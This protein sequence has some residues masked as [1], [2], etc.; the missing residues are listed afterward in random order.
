MI[1]APALQFHQ[2]SAGSNYFMYCP[3]CAC[4]LPA[5]AKFCVRCGAPTGFAP[6]PLSVGTYQIAPGGGASEVGSVVAG[7]SAYCGKCGTRVNPEH[8]FCNACGS[9]LRADV[10]REPTHLHTHSISESTETSVSWNAA[11][12]G[13]TAAWSTGRASE[14]ACL[15]HSRQA[16]R[17]GILGWIWPGFPDKASARKA[18]KVG[19][20]VYIFIVID[21]LAIGLYSL[22]TSESVA[23]HYDAWVLVDGALFAIIAWRLW[24]NS[25]VWA[26]IGLALW[27][28]EI[29]DK[30][31]NAPSTFGVISVL[32]LL[33]IL[34]A[35]RGAFAFHKY[36]IEERR[37]SSLSMGQPD[38]KSVPIQET[39]LP[40]RETQPPI[41]LQES[42][43]SRGAK[44]P[45]VGTSYSNTQAKGSLFVVPP[46]G[47]LPNRCIKCGAAPSEPWLDLTFNWHHPA[48]FL[49]LI[50]P[51]LYLIVSL[52]VA[53][54]VTIAVPLCAM[55]KRIRKQRIWT[56]W[57][58]LVACIPLPVAMATYV[59]N[60]AANTLAVWLG[61]ALFLCGVGTLLAARPLR[62][63]HIGPASAEFSGACPDVLDAME[64]APAL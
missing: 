6:A 17:G 36:T 28:A 13:G 29:V 31:R 5:V 33:A 2:R 37:Q 59:G 3:S 53:K 19:F 7:A 62:A 15:E 63:T 38:V 10:A 27:A 1:G 55:H 60:D 12:V 35:T 52:I 57:L 22:S 23:G 58:M 16:N 24:K 46:G 8:Q 26:V 20:W 41:V 56:G 54:K 32:L 11:Q 18:I 49:L 48:L 4:A 43:E 61:I 47:L 14:T 21:N 44:F 30:L 45:N 34:N 50:S 64:Q 42:S 25:R 39:S 51:L 40:S 9:P